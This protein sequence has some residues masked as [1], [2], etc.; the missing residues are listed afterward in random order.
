MGHVRVNLRLASPERPDQAIE[1]EGALVDTGATHTTL[2]R[3]L[4]DQLGLR[5]IGQLR[6]R[7]AAGWQVLDRSYAYLELEG[8]VTVS[9]V[10]ISDTFDGV[11][12]GVVTL[13]DVGFA[14]DP[15]TGQLK[16]SEILLL[17][18]R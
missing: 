13:E 17:I 16:E 10:L 15:G 11:L 14:V 9:T 18:A 6:V 3:S 4:A 12:I 5:I 1:V 8:K 2:P 7:T